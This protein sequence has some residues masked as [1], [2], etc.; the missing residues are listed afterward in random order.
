MLNETSCHYLPGSILLLLTRS[1]FLEY[2]KA[3]SRGVISP[4]NISVCMEQMVFKV[5]SISDLV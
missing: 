4:I 2:F 3:L 1:F 5:S